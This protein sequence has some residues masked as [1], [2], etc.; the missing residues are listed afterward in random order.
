MAR[1]TTDGVVAKA[2]I[3]PQS[4]SFQRSEAWRLLSE[5]GRIEWSQQW[6]GDERIAD[7]RRGDTSAVWKPKRQNS[8][9][10]FGQ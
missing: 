7:Y 1:L 6:V 9:T 4:T 2:V 8:R 10:G 5:K 3:G